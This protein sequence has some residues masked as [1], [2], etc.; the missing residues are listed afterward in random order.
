[1][2]HTKKVQKSKPVVKESKTRSNKR[3]KFIYNDEPGKKVYLAGNFN[4]WTPYEK[5]LKDKKKTGVYEYSVILPKGKYEY[6]FV[7]DDKWTMD[8]N[9]PEWTHNDMG[10]LN[11]VVTVQ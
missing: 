2:A 6:K 5:Q 9:C 3:I 4:N 7:V 1:M 11:S 10:T 8:P